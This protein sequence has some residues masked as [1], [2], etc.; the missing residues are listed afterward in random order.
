[1]LGEGPQADGHIGQP[2]WQLP[3]AMLLAFATTMVVGSGITLLSA[4]ISQQPLPRKTHFIRIIGL[5]PFATGL[6][7]FYGGILRVG[8]ALFGE[9][10]GAFLLATILCATGY[11]LISIRSQP[12]VNSNSVGEE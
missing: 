8:L 1:M 2:A 7:L 12:E 10:I 6:G 5:A 4:Q 11:W 9:A 3:M